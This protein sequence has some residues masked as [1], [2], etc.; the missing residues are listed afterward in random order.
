[1]ARYSRAVR[2]LLVL[3]LVACGHPADVKHATPGGGTIH[4]V[5]QGSGSAAGSAATP[6]V[7]VADVGCPAPSCAYHAGAA[8]YFTCLAGGAGAC[9]HFGAPCAPADGCMFD[10]ADRTYKSCANPVEGQC[11]QWGAACAPA[12]GCMFDPA[13]GLHHHCDRITGGTCAQYGALCAP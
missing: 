7:A 2:Q 1:V 4:A 10:A 13:D 8:A 5:G 11:R 9:F 12:S 6:P 3:A